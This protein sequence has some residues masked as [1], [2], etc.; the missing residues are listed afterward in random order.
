MKILHRNLASFQFFSLFFLF[1]IFFY[2]PLF[3]WL[4]NFLL[5]NGKAYDISKD[6]GKRRHLIR[7]S[8]WYLV[9]QFCH[10]C[11]I[12]RRFSPFHSAIGMKGFKQVWI[13]ILTKRNTHATRHTRPGFKWQANVL[14]LAM[15]EKIFHKFLSF[16]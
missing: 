14:V 16:Y 7:E 8:F 3:P 9:F 5:S 12:T 15:N 13:K 11:P 6:F 2:L 1:L 4:W 10:I